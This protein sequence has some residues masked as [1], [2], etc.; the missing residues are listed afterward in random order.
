MDWRDL[1]PFL[2]KCVRRAVV[3]LG[4]VLIWLHTQFTR[5]LDIARRVDLNNNAEF[6]IRRPA[7]VHPVSEDMP[8]DEAGV[9]SRNIWRT[10][11]SGNYFGEM[12]EKILYVV[13]QKY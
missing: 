8:S 3:A 5:V 11:F 2:W 4:C 1:G 13:P 9:D 12:R 7:V 6:V 10:K